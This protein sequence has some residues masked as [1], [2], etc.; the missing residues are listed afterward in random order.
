MILMNI[1]L[2]EIIGNHGIEEN[3]K[4]SNGRTVG[5]PG[6]L[7]FSYMVNTRE[8]KI[9]LVIAELNKLFRENWQRNKNRYDSKKESST[10]KGKPK[11]NKREWD[12]SKIQCHKCRK[13]G[14][15]RKNCKESST[16]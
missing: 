14:H 1:T 5:K 9:D 3:I 7:T 6:K 10:Y 11:W 2:D 12:M 16:T 13:F 4:T 15:F 8:W